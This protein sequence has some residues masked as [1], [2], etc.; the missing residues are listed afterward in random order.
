MIDD[1]TVPL[2]SASFVTSNLVV[3]PYKHNFLPTK[4]EGDIYQILTG[5]IAGTLV[6]RFINVPNLG[7][8]FIKILSPAD[9]LV[10]APDG[11]KIAYL[12]R[13]SQLE[14]DN[15]LYVMDIN[16]SPFAFGTG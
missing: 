9:F 1:E 8:L 12:V 6:E 7:L 3:T 5:R 11:K 4:T 13:N 14:S 2:T 16:S 10:V 15:G